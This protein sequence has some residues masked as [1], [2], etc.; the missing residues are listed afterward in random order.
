MLLNS[1]L[2]AIFI[3]VC[4]LQ[5]TVATYAQER[6]PSGD[7]SDFFNP[8]GV[9]SENLSSTT[10]KIDS[11]KK[12]TAKKTADNNANTNTNANSITKDTAKPDAESKT[13]GAINDSAKTVDSPSPES[14][15]M[16]PASTDETIPVPPKNKK[17]GEKVKIE[18]Q[19]MG[20]IEGGI[21]FGPPT[22]I[23][24]RVGL[25]MVTGNKAVNNVICR[26]P[27]PIQWPEQT[28]SVFEEDLPPEI[29]NVSWEDLGNIRMMKCR[30]GNVPPKTRVIATVTFRVSTSQIIAPKNTSIF[31]IPEKRTRDI[32]PYFGESPEISLRNTKMKKQA[33]EIF[34]TSQSDWM[35]VQGLFD[36]I[37]ENIEERDGEAKGS[38]EAFLDKFGNSEDRVSLFIAMCR[39]NKVPARM[40]FVDGSQYAEFYLVDDKKQGHWF[41]CKVSGIREFGS[42]GE[43]RVILQKG[44]NYRMPGERK[45]L[46]FVPAKGQV[47]GGS[48]PRKLVFIR[49]PLS[50]K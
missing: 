2:K 28:V 37:R 15:G 13:D 16:Q 14:G 19:E 17:A 35:K 49:E 22:D 46:K 34:D 44:D 42:I 47:K 26:I 12:K 40:V 33:K 36:W 39:I 4:V 50:V 31:R 10:R 38:V 11:G 24:W 43:P 21:S 48:P 30:I 6:V 20:P 23:K 32:K 27:V 25:G 1:T 29:T 18:S 41:P 3:S 45:K 5:M 8:P 9:K 7:L